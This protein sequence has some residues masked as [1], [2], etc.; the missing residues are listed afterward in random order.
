MTNNLTRA[1]KLM[2]AARFWLI[3]MAENDEQYYQVLKA[4]EIASKH[5]N[6][7]RN[8]GDPEIIHQLGIFHRLRT[9]H[10]HIKNPVTV[11]CLVFLHDSLEDPNQET[12]EYISPQLIEEEFGLEFLIKLKKMSKEIMGVKNPDYSL[13][14]IFED[15][16]TG[17]AK[18]GDR[19]D[20]VSS[21]YG[22]FKPERLARYVK[23]TEEQFLPLIKVHRRKFPYQEA[24]MEN[25]KLSLVNQLRLIK[26]KREEHDPT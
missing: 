21:M 20:N 5:H 11:Y 19:D 17:V 15:E 1:D 9:L 12:K 6:G 10:R 24:V 13:Q 25:L 18:L 2:L 23:E 4:L 8:G 14:T 26:S 16:D 7:K 22:V 3:G